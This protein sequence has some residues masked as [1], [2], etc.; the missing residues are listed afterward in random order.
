MKAFL[1]E[2]VEYLNNNFNVAINFEV[3]SWFFP[4]V[5]EESKLNVLITTIAKLAI[6][7][8]KYKESRPNVRH[9]CSL[10]KFEAEKE[11]RS[12]I[13]RNAKDKF[14]H[15]WGNVSKILSDD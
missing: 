7:K 9:F 8:A 12:A 2:I 6:F 14:T 1:Q 10:L 13:L 11:E 4:Q 15:K 3:Q 5:A